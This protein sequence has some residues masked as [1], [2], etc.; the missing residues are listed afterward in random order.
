MDVLQPLGCPAGGIGAV[1]VNLGG[2]A[3]G[4]R[5]RQ[6]AEDPAS[7]EGEPAATAGRGHDEHGDHEAGP[8][9]RPQK[10][11]EGP[12]DKEGVGR[13]PPSGG[14]AGRAAEEPEPDRHQR[15]ATGPARANAVAGA[16][17]MTFKGGL[18]G[19]IPL[20]RGE[21][22]ITEAVTISGPP[23]RLLAVMSTLSG[24]SVWANIFSWYASVL[25]RPST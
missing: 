12:V 25:I 19:M 13:R 9:H 3:A 6:P 17:T 1:A 10:P 24:M 8:D 20:T 7:L 2:P 11:V 21:L 5:K 23:T 22:R 14:D 15:D 16:N 18:S 4:R